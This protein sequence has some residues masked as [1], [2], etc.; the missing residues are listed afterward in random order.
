MKKLRWIVAF[1][2]LAL[3]L[4]T[5]GA[6]VWGGSLMATAIE[7]V[8]TPVLGAEV[9]VR[10]GSLDV[11]TGSAGVRDLT[12]ANPAGFESPRAFSAS[13]MELGVA[14]GSIFSD[15]IVIP[16]VVLE[17]PEIT[18][19]TGPG[20]TNWGTLMDNARRYQ[21]APPADGSAKKRRNVKIGELRI[22]GAR[23]QLAQSVVKEIGSTPVSV[24]LSEIVIRDFSTGNDGAPLS[25]VIE[26]VV[27]AILDA[28][29]KSGGKLPAQIAKAL[30]SEA[31]KAAAAIEEQA[32]DLGKTLGDDV[33]KAAKEAGDAVK[34]GAEDVG[35]A[36]DGIF[37][38]N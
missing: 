26:Q 20:G 33:G 15:P 38:K 27:A 16:R 37:K 19:E 30:E 4:A 11:L 22:T 7:K 14:I 6:S 2:L 3:I 23:V 12:V 9:A 13:N 28:A 1:V 25:E 18:L 17:A 8:G 10:K 29:A 35:K 31:R 36:L 5:L 34:K 24:E 32:R 21:G